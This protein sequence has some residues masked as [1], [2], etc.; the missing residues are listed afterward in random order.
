VRAGGRNES[1]RPAC[2][3]DSDWLCTSS[4][5]GICQQRDEESEL[6][7][8]YVGSGGNYKQVTTYKY[9]GKGEGE[10]QI[11]RPRCHGTSPWICIVTFLGMTAVVL[12]FFTLRW[13]SSVDDED[14]PPSTG[15]RGHFDCSSHGNRSNSWSEAQR[16]WCCRHE[17]T[18]GCGTLQEALHANNGHSFNCLADVASWRSDWSIKKQDWC[19]RHKGLGCRAPPYQHSVTGVPFHCDDS[20]PNSMGAW[21]DRQRLLC[22]LQANLG[23]PEGLHQTW[24]KSLTTTTTTTNTIPQVRNATVLAA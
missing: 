15:R 7:P 12:P 19:C 14:P 21:S 10:Y 20:T 9:V 2:G 8:F 1:S 11:S 5:R 22:C 13:P 4:G 3:T 24:A 18:V 16:A 6:T 17:S 23:C